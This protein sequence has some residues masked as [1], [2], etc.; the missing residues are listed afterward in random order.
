MHNGFNLGPIKG[1][2][3][4]DNSHSILACRNGSVAYRWIR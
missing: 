1:V 4:V 2:L 3:G